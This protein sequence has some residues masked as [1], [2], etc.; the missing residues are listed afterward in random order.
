MEE[1]VRRNMELFERTFSMFQPF[2]AAQALGF[3]RRQRAVAAR[4]RSPDN[5]DALR[6]RR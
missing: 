1:Q 5:I 2:Q 4:R 6:K 3:G